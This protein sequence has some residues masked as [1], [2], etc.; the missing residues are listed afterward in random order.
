LARRFD[1][2]GEPIIIPQ[3][4]SLAT[5]VCLSLYSAV[6]GAFADCSG[7]EGA[8]PDRREPMVVSGGQA[9]R[10]SPAAHCR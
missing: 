5:A 10:K 2:D 3:T 7:Q 8:Q 4:A 6:P 9:R 1:R